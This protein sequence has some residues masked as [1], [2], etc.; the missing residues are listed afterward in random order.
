MALDLGVPTLHTGEGAA[1]TETEFQAEVKA[2]YLR[3]VKD[4]VRNFLTL[5]LFLT[6]VAWVVR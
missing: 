6:V 1:M 3:G 2:A 4:T 5:A